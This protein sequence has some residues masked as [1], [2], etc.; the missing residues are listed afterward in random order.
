ML[1]TVKKIT[2]TITHNRLRAVDIMK[3]SAELSLR[4]KSLRAV[5]VTPA[6]KVEARFDLIP[7]S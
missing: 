6:E 7:T 3:P 1:K 5:N 2:I 4:L